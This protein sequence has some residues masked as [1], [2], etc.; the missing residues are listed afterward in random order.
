M[1]NAIEAN[2]FSMSEKPF[3]ISAAVHTISNETAESYQ[4][5]TLSNVLSNDDLHH[6]Q[7]TPPS[8]L[9]LIS[10]HQVIQPTLLH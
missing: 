1:Y 5:P 4:D 3:D 9:R 10:L 8:R 6:G 7:I 2:S